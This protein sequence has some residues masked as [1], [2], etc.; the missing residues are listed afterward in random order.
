MDTYTSFND[1]TVSQEVK[2]KVATFDMTSKRFLAQKDNLAQLLKSC[3]AEYACYDPE[4]I[5]GNFIEPNIA[6]ATT[7]VFPSIHGM[8]TEDITPEGDRVTLFFEPCF[9]HCP[10]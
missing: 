2:R 10:S 1:L 5:A 7:D 3:I 8:P 4:L 6:V 9:L